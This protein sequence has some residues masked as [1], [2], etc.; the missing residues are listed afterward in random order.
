MH[1]LPMPAGAFQR[2][3]QG[4]SLP[5]NAEANASYAYN[6]KTKTLHVDATEACFS[7]TR[8]WGSRPIFALKVSI[9]VQGSTVEHAIMRSFN[10]P[11]TEAP[12]EGRA[13]L[14]S[15][16]FL[17]SQKV[18]EHHAFVVVY[19][20]KKNEVKISAGAET[21]LK[22]EGMLKRRELAQGVV[23]SVLRPEL[24]RVVKVQETRRCE[25]CGKENVIETEMLLPY[26]LK[27]IGLDPDTHVVDDTASYALTRTG[28]CRACCPAI[29]LQVAELID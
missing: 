15:L 20:N 3:I 9:P 11:K 12:C 25:N 1:T 2:L 21:R 13:F 4:F 7:V 10:P 29:L 17:K 22:A 19:L 28:V 14:A 8:T 27:T 18:K 23:M 26:Y 16:G 24:H 6:E 5:L